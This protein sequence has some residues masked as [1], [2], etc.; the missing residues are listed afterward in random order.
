M[1]MEDHDQCACP[2]CDGREVPAEIIA[3]IKEAAAGPMSRRM[4][5]EEFKAWLETF[6]GSPR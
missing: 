5:A 3:R 4:S 2:F 1:S 6:P